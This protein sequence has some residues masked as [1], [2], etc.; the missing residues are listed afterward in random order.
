ML[1]R[2]RP[3]SAP[4]STPSDQSS[5]FAS[6]P[7]SPSPSPLALAGANLC[8]RYLSKLSSHHRTKPFQLELGR[9]KKIRYALLFLLV[10]EK[11]KSKRG[12]KRERAALASARV[13]GDAVRP[14]PDSSSAAFSSRI[15][16][17]ELSLSLSISTLPPSSSATFAFLSTSA[18]ASFPDA[19]LLPVH[20]MLFL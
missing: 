4:A 7:L 6:H 2:K 20:P 19:A 12:K 10:A 18:P 13:K 14:P 5:A 9:E 11:Q 17:K 8:E 15:T 3:S 16:K 1:S